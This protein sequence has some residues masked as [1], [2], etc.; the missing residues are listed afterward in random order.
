MRMSPY[1][2]YRVTPE[3]F[4]RLEE[5]G[6]H[7]PYGS[8]GKALDDVIRFTDWM[9]LRKVEPP[10][11][12]STWGLHAVNASLYIPL[13]RGYHTTSYINAAIEKAYAPLLRKYE[14]QE[15]LES[16]SSDKPLKP[17]R[18]PSESPRVYNYTLSKE[19]YARLGEIKRIRCV[20]SKSE[21]LDYVLDSTNW[22]LLTSRKLPRLRRERG[23][24][25][26]RATVPPPLGGT[27]NTPR[28][29]NAAVLLMDLDR[30][31]PA[32]PSVRRAYE[33]RND[34]VGPEIDNPASETIPARPRKPRPRNT[35]YRLTEESYEKLRQLRESRPDLNS[36]TDALTLVIDTTDWEALGNTPSIPYLTVHDAPR[37]VASRVSIPLGAGPSF[38]SLVNE[39]VR[40]WTPDPR[41]CSTH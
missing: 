17:F 40:R 32:L 18:R 28:L 6:H 3:N 5:L 11:I 26:M 24:V 22:E 10:Y 4:K 27:G 39:A 12:S 1:I 25:H 13:R 7:H 20:R 33:G 14:A 16:M 21:A 15:A 38:I 8:R 35:T 30:I 9:E 37:Q 19:A 29:V 36:L 31:P 34:T 23:T 41:P 2:K